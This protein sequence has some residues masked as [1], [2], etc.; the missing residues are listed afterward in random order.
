MLCF[1]ESI[2]VT[3]LFV[4]MEPIDTYIISQ[5]PA[6][7]QLMVLWRG[8]NLASVV[9]VH[10]KATTLGRKLSFTPA[11]EIVFGCYVKTYQWEVSFVS[12]SAGTAARELQ[13]Q[14]CRQRVLSWLRHQCT[15][16]AV[17][18]GSHGVLAPSSPCRMILTVVHKLKQK[19]A[20]VQILEI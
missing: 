13:A 16:A 17:Q 10:W 12:T 2:Y 9:L 20:W 1:S 5:T 11:G 6:T 14:L 19:K 18:A 15:E 8:I 3:S 7:F 4:F